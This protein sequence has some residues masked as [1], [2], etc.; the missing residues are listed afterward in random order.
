[1]QAGEVVYLRYHGDQGVI[2]TRLLAGQTQGDEWMIITPDQDIY[3]EELVQH[4]PDLQYMWRAPD[5]RL[6]EECRR[7]S[8][9]GSVR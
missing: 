6:A 9:T 3:V 8:C 7:I 5:G 1:M 2:H 4:N